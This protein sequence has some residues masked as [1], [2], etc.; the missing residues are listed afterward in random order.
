[1]SSGIFQGVIAQLKEISDRTY[2]VVDTDGVVISCT[3]ATLL[4]ERWPDAVLKVANGTEDT[5]TFNQKTFKAI[6]NAS[7]CLEYAVF[8][9]GDDEAAKLH[10]Q[11][12]YISL[13]GAK[14]FYE[15]KH[16]S[17]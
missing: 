6:I 3:D 7:N 15:E 5:T 17:F 8:C 16:D 13:N 9:S 11:M 14:L 10:C 2:G 12:A 1:M 4:G